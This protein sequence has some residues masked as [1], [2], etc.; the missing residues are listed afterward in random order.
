MGTDPVTLFFILVSNIRSA[1]FG[2]HGKAR[3]HR[4]PLRTTPQIAPQKKKRGEKNSL[5][6]VGEEKLHR[7]DH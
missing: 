4:P 1:S 6:L 3:N 2:N 7:K 5:H